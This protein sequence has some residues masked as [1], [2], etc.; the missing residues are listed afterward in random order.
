M[1]HAM[2]PWILVLLLAGPAALARPADYQFDPVH[3]Q[4]MFFADHLGFSHPMGRFGAPTGS[5]QFDPDD[6]ASASVDA[7][8]EVA[9]LDL[10]DAAWQRKMLS[11]EFFDAA[12][13]PTM[14]FVS[15]RIEPTG[16]DTLRIHGQLTLRGVTRPLTLETRV[17]RI[18][19]HSFSM[20]YVAGFSATATLK[21]SDFGMTRLLAAVGDEVELRFEIEGIRSR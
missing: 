17:N 7:T 18:G 16:K 10:G 21:R 20:K 13:H 6:W 2:R 5:F 1:L 9:S 19:R 15:E 3:S 14:R 12:A 8:I 4:V 11:D